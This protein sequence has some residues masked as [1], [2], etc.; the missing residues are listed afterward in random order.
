VKPA[1]L[2]LDVNETLSDMSPLAARFEAVG[3]PAHL[4][5]AWFAGVLR[6]GFALAAGGDYAD[7]ADVARAALHSMLSEVDGL[8]Q[9]PREAAEHIMAGLSQLTLHPDVRPGLEQLHAAGVRLVALTNGSTENASSLLERSDLA[10]LIE[11]VLSVESVRRWKPSPAPYAYAAS[12]CDVPPEQ[13]T[14]AAGTQTVRAAR[15]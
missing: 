14:L 4:L 7:F 13:V 5:P 10:G 3:A 6:D 8:G 2:V 11:R 1:V 15:V 12:M 9:S